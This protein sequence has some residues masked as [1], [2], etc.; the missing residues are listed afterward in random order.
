MLTRTH[1]LMGSFAFFFYFSILSPISTCGLVFNASNLQLGLSLFFFCCINKFG[2][3]F[4]CS[5]RALTGNIFA[6]AMFCSFFDRIY[7]QFVYFYSRWPYLAD[8]IFFLVSL[9]TFI[10]I[11]GCQSNKF[12]T[13]TSLSTVRRLECPLF[14]LSGHSSGAN[15]MNESWWWWNRHALFRHFNK[16]SGQCYEFQMT[17]EMKCESLRTIVTECTGAPSFAWPCLSFMA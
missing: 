15:V 13:R 1:S 12:L 10:K 2:T 14:G 5:P 7:L 17:V 3:V 8:E 16:L 4:H 9:V 11:C 6:R